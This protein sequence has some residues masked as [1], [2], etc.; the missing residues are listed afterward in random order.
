VLRFVDGRPVSHVTIDFLEWVW[1]RLAQN[2]KKVLVLVGDNA[3]GHISPMVRQWLR[4]HNAKVKREGGV[5]ILKCF[6]PV[7]SPWFNPIE[8]HWG[9]GKRASVAPART[10]TAEELRHRVCHYFECEPVEHLQQKVS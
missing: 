10:L 1:G 9:H 5:R 7:K 4:T 3:S 8:P 2:G 6:L